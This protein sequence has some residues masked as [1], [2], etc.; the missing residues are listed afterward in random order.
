VTYHNRALVA[1]SA[2]G[3]VVCIVA[4]LPLVTG[5]SPNIPLMGFGVVIALIGAWWHGWRARRPGA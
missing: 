1:Y 2:V 3:G 4:L 5:R